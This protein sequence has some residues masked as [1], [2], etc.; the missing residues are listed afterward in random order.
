MLPFLLP[1]PSEER[2]ALHEA[3]N[4]KYLYDKKC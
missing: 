4:G 1:M 3:E 2:I